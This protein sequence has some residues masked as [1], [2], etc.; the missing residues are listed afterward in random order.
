MEKHKSCIRNKSDN[1]ENKSLN[2]LN[3]IESYDAL[4]I[5][6]N[7]NV[8]Q[9]N[10]TKNI[11]DNLNIQNKVDIESNDNNTKDSMNNN[12][13]KISEEQNEEYKN[14]KQVTNSQTIYLPEFPTNES[15]ENNE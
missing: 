15:I 14:D 10:N 11:H 8:K 12:E 1:N 4:G 6:P 3:K 2:L 9:D 13:Q 7:M 5:N